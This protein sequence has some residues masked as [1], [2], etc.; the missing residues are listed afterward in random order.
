LTQTNDVLEAQLDVMTVEEADWIDQKVLVE[1]GACN[2][3]NQELGCKS[4][5]L[6]VE[7]T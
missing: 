4:I 1:S 2:A 7:V 6:D 3:L 5:P